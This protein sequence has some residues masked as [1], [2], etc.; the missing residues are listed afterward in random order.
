M[1]EINGV[2]KDFG[3]RALN[4]DDTDKLF[5]EIEELYMNTKDHPNIQD[6]EALK[7]SLMEDIEL[8]GAYIA[9]L[10]KNKE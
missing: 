10:L 2:L 5:K 7:N 9:N 1:N 8:K 3:E 6:L 4:S